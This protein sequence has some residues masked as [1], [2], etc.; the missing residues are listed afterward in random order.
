VHKN[1]LV[2]VYSALQERGL[3]LAFHGYPDWE[4]RVIGMMERYAG[5]Q[6]LG[7]PHYN[8][9][10]LA[11]WLMHG[12]PE[13]FPSL[14]VLWMGAG[15]AW[16]QYVMLRLDQSYMTRSFDFPL[17]KERPSH[18]MRKMFYCTQPLEREQ[19][20]LIEPLFEALDGENQFV[21]G[22]S[23]PNHD[24]DLPSVI[25]DLPFLSEPAKRNILGGNAQKLFGIKAAN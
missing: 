25:W 19:P 12:M 6:A 16:V 13:R 5:I 3:A 4:D 1:K 11:N 10:H 7:K 20:Q 9:V 15:L 8:I 2:P 22:S 18:Y 17:L 21:W 14:K 24:F 23:Y